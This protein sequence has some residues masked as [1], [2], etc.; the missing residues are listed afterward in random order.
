MAVGK[1][2]VGGGLLLGAIAI[3]AVLAGLPFGLGR[4]V[5]DLW[6]GVISVVAQLVMSVFG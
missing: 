2:T 4:V 3:V 5:A 1:G 6:I